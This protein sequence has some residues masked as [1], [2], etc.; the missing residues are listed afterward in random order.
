MRCLTL[1]AYN[2]SDQT[3]TTAQDQT[4]HFGFESVTEAEKEK[5]GLFIFELCMHASIDLRVFSA[6]HNVVYLSVVQAQLR[7]INQFT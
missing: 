3:N 6:M 2:C 5:K 1:S 4:T 7:T